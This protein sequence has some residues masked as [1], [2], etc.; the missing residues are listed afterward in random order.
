MA[1]A[2]L[3]ERRTS[4]FQPRVSRNYARPETPLDE[5][6]RMARMNYKERFGTR[7]GP[8]LAYSIRTRRGFNPLFWRRTTEGGI[9][10]DLAKM[11]LHQ[12]IEAGIID[13]PGKRLRQNGIA[14][15]FRANR[16]SLSVVVSLVRGAHGIPKMSRG[17]PN[18]VYPEELNATIGQIYLKLPKKGEVTDF[19]FIRDVALETGGRMA[20]Y[21]HVIGTVRTLEQKHERGITMIPV[22]P[23]EAKKHM[24]SL[25]ALLRKDRKIVRSGIQLR[26]FLGTSIVY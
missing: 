13:D 24:D 19:A 4:V 17:G 8:F 3:L 22:I 11:G 18:F 12:E 9:A 21:N 14:R 6:I 1:Q 2:A 10:T 25:M 26:R 15:R 5:Y 16:R 23:Y 7:K 20:A